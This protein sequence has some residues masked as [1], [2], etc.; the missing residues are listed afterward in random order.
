V[1]SAR[2]SSVRYDR[3]RE[4]PEPAVDLG[5]FRGRLPGLCC[6]K[7]L[8]DDQDLCPVQLALIPPR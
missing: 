1:P 4:L 6:R 7:N 3:F 2:M 5:R 8:S